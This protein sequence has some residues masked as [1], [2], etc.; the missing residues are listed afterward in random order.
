MDNIQINEWKLL[1]YH[2]P[3]D[4]LRRIAEIQLIIAKSSFDDKTKTL[5]TNHLK[6]H[7]EGR[8]A[9]LFCHGLGKAVL[10]RKVYFSLYEKDDYDFVTCWQDQTT[11]VYTPVQLKEVVPRDLNPET[12][13]NE[14][15]AKLSKY[16]DSANLVVAMFLNRTGRLKI[17]D[18]IVPGLNIGEL[19]LFGF[20]SKDQ[21]KW[22][23][24]GD[25]LGD[26]RYFEFDYPN[27]VSGS[28]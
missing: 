2:D 23:L 11:L 19:R 20:T 13:L 18:I 26:R 9:A 1:G 25:L 16:T 27:G 28:E 4:A 8:E 5:R 3:Q 17:G 10:N 21:S 15:I 12:T 24:L 6:P 7:K 22:F 14:E